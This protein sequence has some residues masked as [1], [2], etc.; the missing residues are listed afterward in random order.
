MTG[1]AGE[2]R[3]PPFRGRLRDA[4]MP[5]RAG[6]RHAGRGWKVTGLRQCR[7]RRSSGGPSRGPGAAAMTGPRARRHPGCSAALRA[8]SAFPARSLACLARNGT[9]QLGARL[10]AA[11][12]PLTP[13][14]R[15]PF[16][17]PCAV[18]A[19]AQCPP[20]TASVA[21]CRSAAQG[22]SSIG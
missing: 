4:V 2:R 11:S 10:P 6:V 3:G 16:Y 18:G 17:A 21:G 7:L 20:S 9:A 19:R 22:C 15:G 12:L 13:T 8:T 1:G 5:S 14:R